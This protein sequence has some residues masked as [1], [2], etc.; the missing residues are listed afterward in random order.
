MSPRHPGRGVPLGMD[1]TDRGETVP[2][3]TLQ[4]I[5]QNFFWSFALKTTGDQKCL[6]L[7]QNAEVIVV[8]K[9]RTIF[10]F[11]ISKAKVRLVVICSMFSLVFEVL[12][13]VLYLLALMQTI[14][15]LLAPGKTLKEQ[16]LVSISALRVL[17]H[18]G[19]C[20]VTRSGFDLISLITA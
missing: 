10:C 11:Y 9:K 18:S 7:G 13:M 3:K 20:S 12:P 4:L 19:M 16:L 6:A 14:R 5:L 2:P 17:C 1:S 8:L 15:I